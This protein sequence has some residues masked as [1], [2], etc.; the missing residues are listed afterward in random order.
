MTEKSERVAVGLTEEQKQKLRVEAAK[1][2]VSM[3]EL[4]REII[5]NELSDGGGD[6]GNARPRTATAD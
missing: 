2:G 6:S 1:R 5:L 4:V 3:A